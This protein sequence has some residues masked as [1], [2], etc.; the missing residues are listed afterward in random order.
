LDKQKTGL[1]RKY[2]YCLEQ[3]AAQTVF[4]KLKYLWVL[5]FAE[6]FQLELLRQNGIP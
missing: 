6:G 5:G 3:K 1:S 4:R 2:T